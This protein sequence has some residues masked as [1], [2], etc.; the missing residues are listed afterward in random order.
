MAAVPVHIYNASGAGAANP[1]LIQNPLPADN[2]PIIVLDTAAN[3]AAANWTLLA[4][5]GSHGPARNDSPGIYSNGQMNCMS[6]LVAFFNPPMVPGAQWANCYLAHVS[7]RRAKEIQIVIDQLTPENAGQ[8]Y[9]VIGGKEGVLPGMQEIAGRFETAPSP[10][11]QIL[12][13]SANESNRFA[14]GMRRSGEFGQVNY[15]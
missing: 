11:R 5:A 2:G 15:G 9:V 14:F 8:A 13:Y 12:I 6:I 10:P 1:L 3:L 4:D 7:H